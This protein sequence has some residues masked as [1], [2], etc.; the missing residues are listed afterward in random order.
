VLVFHFV[1]CFRGAAERVNFINNS[2]ILCSFTKAT[3]ALKFSFATIIV[4]IICSC[5]KKFCGR[6]TANIAAVPQKH[7][8]T[9]WFTKSVSLAKP[10]LGRCL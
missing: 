9:A 5:P 4:P 1:Y 2:T 8:A 6:L 10:S 3:I 7:Y